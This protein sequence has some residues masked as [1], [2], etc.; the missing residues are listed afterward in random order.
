[1]R[2]LY[3]LLLGILLFANYS[4]AQ[5]EGLYLDNTTQDISEGNDPRAEQNCEIDFQSLNENDNLNI[6]CD[7]NLNGETIIVPQNVT[8]NFD[9]GS[10]T[11]G[12][13]IFESGL[14]DGRLLNIDLEING[15]TRIINSHFV[16]EKEKWNIVEGATN[17]ATAL[18]NRKNINAAITL[19][20]SLGANI[21]EIDNI[22]AYVEVGAYHFGNYTHR[23][24]IQV[25]SNFHF[26]MGDNC[27]LRVQPNGNISYAILSSRGVNNVKISGGHLIGD[28]YEH[29][30][31][32]G[33]EQDTHEFG[34]GIYFVGV[35][36]S[37]I[38]GVTVDDM[39][40]DSFGVHS[41][42]NRNPDGSEVAGQFYSKNILIKNVIFRGA[43]RNNLSF[44]DIDG[45]TLENSIIA[46]AGEGGDISNYGEVYDWRGVL[47]RCNI[48]L[49]AT[50]SFDADGNLRISQIVQNII[51]RNNEF[52][53]AYISDINFYTCKNVEVYGNTFTSGLSNLNAQNISIHDNTFTHD[54]TLDA[55]PIAIYMK[56]FIR[57]GTG[58]EENLN[59]QIYNNTVYGFNTAISVGGNNHNVYN[60]T[61]NNFVNNGISLR[62]G[63]NNHFSGNTISSNI[64]GSKGYY[65]F[66]T[67][68]SLINSTITDETINV[69]DYG[70]LF[71]NLNSYSGSP[72]IIDNCS[73]S[74]DFRNV[75]IRNSSSITVQNSE[76][77]TIYQTNNTNI[78]LSNNN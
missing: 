71:K 41:T 14:I 34:T 22:D 68:I 23:E 16:F 31:T 59:Y 54:T 36:N 24:A 19:V 26:K 58:I 63:K 12:T 43:R 55:L 72:V 65:S 74:S 20:K 5:D 38:D 64:S 37:E 33:T 51:I 73:F 49:E 10:L 40:G 66:P 47:P 13:L 56:E 25:P 21:L 44:I 1:M 7:Y 15:S 29:T 53:G 4:C 8:F 9:G 70:L 27:T 48:D 3:L 69:D 76:T 78:V 57:E 35:T 77:G 39:T 6:S 30:Y 2:P 32:T 42:R 52:T 18:T 45:L 67:G 62:S 75:D 50:R 28:K 46:N 60:N 11:N 17:Y 61:V